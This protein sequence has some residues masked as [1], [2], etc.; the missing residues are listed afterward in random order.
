[1]AISL[2]FKIKKVFGKSRRPTVVAPQLD[3]SWGR[4][5]ELPI[6]GAKALFLFKLS[7]DRVLICFDAIINQMIADKMTRGKPSTPAEYEG[8]FKDLDHQILFSL[9]MRRILHVDSSPRASSLVDKCEA[10]HGYLKRSLANLRHV[11]TA[12]NLSSVDLFKLLG[13]VELGAFLARFD[14]FLGKTDLSWY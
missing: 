4:V 10:V 3:I 11:L 7:Q 13:R 1:M 8:L 9:A 6:E 2:G 14:T 5:N 12:P